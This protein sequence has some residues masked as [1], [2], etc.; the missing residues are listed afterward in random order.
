MAK[1]VMTR[2][3]RAL[4]WTAASLAALVLLIGLF[5]ATLFDW[6]WVKAPL[7]RHLGGTL[8]RGIAI[9]GD[10]AVHLGRVIR[11]RLE[12]VRLANAPWA[13]T[14]DMADFAAIDLE[15]RAWPLLS[16]RVEVADLDLTRPVLDLEKNRQGEA[17]WSF[18]ANPKAAIAEKAVVP[19]K[20]TEFPQIDRLA[21][22]HG[23]LRFVDPARGIDIDSSADTATG[24]DPSHAQLRL[25]AKGSLQGRPARLDLEAGSLLTLKAASEPYPLRMNATIGATHL[26]VDGTVAEPLDMQGITIRMA[27]SGG[28]LAEVFPIF[29]IPLPH[30]RAY[31]LEGELVRNGTV[32]T[33]RQFRGRV[34]GSDLAG[35]LSVEAGVQPPRLKA[36]LNSTNLALSDLGGLVGTSPGRETP[37]KPGHVLPDSPI[38]LGKLRAMDMDVSFKGRHVEAPHLPIDAMD[39]HLLLDRG[40]AQLK[41]LSFAVADGSFAGTV[42]LDGSH[43]VPAVSIT[44]E[45]N[46]INLRRFL[47]GADFAGDTGGTLAGRLDLNGTG[48]STAEIL[49]HSG[50][51]VSL[52]MATG[53]FSH[54]LLAAAG[55]SIDK[56]LGI[57]LTGDQ[58]IPVRCLV[59]DFAVDEGRMNARALVLDT[60]STIITG[61][62]NIDLDDEALDLKLIAHPKS[63]S[64]LS[65][66]APV[67]IKGT[68]AK[69]DI[70]IDPKVEAARGG[71]AAVLGVLLTPLAAFLPFGDLGLGHDSPCRQL[72]QQ[73]E[74][75]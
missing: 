24:G 51:H 18:G 53:S 55:L 58:A 6:N 74:R 9:D 20:R 25:A 23:R 62:G 50:G 65:A 67:L 43:E 21:I 70:G 73:A 3:L 16:G 29:G 11:V 2:M 60:T 61:A 69:P 10:I 37:T 72:I 19:Q 56:A 42:V 57:E 32:W 1:R 30:T 45:V 47:A 14:P 41:P 26:T 46:R 39:A 40:R 12:G 5:I 7:T 15:V 22:H 38:D 54:L 44:M 48:R 52:F 71:A 33:F 34:G 66:R 28:D 4:A 49:G 59:T 31:S 64:L 35:D 17:N 8:H 13:S 75:P 36:V 68:L 27:L 63:P